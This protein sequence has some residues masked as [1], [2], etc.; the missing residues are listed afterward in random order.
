MR[1]NRNNLTNFNILT[2]KKKLIQILMLAFV[3]VSIGSFVSCKDTNEDLYNQ[4][5]SEL[6]AQT[7]QTLAAR[8][9][10][11]Q[12]DLQSHL[13]D[14]QTL[15]G[16]VNY[17]LT[18]CTNVNTTITNLQN[19][20]NALQAALGGDL[21][22]LVDPVTG[23]PTS[24]LNYLNYLT[25]QLNTLTQNYN[26]LAS[27]PADL[28]ALQDALNAAVADLQNQ[29][30]NINTSGCSCGDLV[31]RVTALEQKMATA[32][33]NI[34]AALGRLDN[35]EGAVNAATQ[36]AQQAADA[37][38]AAAQVA[39]QADA[40]ADEAL[41][42]AL[43]AINTA[44]ALQTLVET[45]TNN[46]TILQ[47]A[48]Q[49]IQNTLNQYGEQIGANTAAIQQNAQDIATNV[50]NIQKNADDIAELKNK[51]NE[52][53]TKLTL[54]ST[55][56]QEAFDKAT[57]ALA[58]AEV[59]EAAISTLNGQVAEHETAIQDL[60]TAVSTL[61]EQVNTNTS[62]I[63]T[64]KD[65]VNTLNTTVSEL[66]TKV[67]D[68]SDKL[69]NLENELNQ[70]KADCAT[71]LEA[72]KA[73]TDEQIAALKIDELAQQ[74]SDNTDAI[75]AINEALE[76]IKSCECDP[77][78]I[79]DILTRLA[80]AEGNIEDIQ[81]EIADVINKNIEE[82]AKQLN[83]LSADHD[84]LK[85]YVQN[86]NY[87]TPE[88]VEELVKALADNINDVTDDLADDLADALADIID[89][90]SR[91]ELLENTTVKIDDYVADKQDILDKIDANEV[92]I[93]DLEDRADALENQVATL[94]EDL[95]TLTGRV[96]AAE[97][98]LD[99]VEAEVKGLKEDVAALQDYLAKMV[100]G[101]TLQGTIN[102]WFGAISTPFDVQ[103]NILITFY[104]R[105]KSEIEFP[106]NKTGNYV[107]ADEALTDEDMEMIEGVE[108]FEN[109]ANVP[110]IYENGYA[111]KIYMTIN[112]NTADVT[113]L[114]PLIVNSKD[115]V[116][117]FT[118][119]PI[120]PCTEGALQFGWTS[121]TRAQ[122]SNG[123]YMAKVGIKKAD[124]PRISEPSFQTSKMIDALKNA[125]QA[126][127]TLAETHSTSGTASNL[128]KI[129][130]DILS[131]VK[132]LSFDRSGLKVSYT[133]TDA[134]GAET[135]HSVYSEYNLAATGFQPLGL[136]TL[137]D[138]DV[139]TIPGYKRA[140]NLLDRLAAKL[141]SEISVYFNDFSG[142][143]LVTK[144]AS[145]KIN[146]IDLDHNMDP[147]NFI[148]TIDEDVTID[149][150]VFKLVE[151]LN[152][153]K[154]CI[155][156]RIPA[157]LSGVSTNI[158]TIFVDVNGIDTTVL[159][160]PV[161]DTAG[162]VVGFATIDLNDIVADTANGIVASL[163]NTTI[164]L[165]EG[166]YDIPMGT[167]SR[168]IYFGDPVLDPVTGLPVFV[169]GQ[170]QYSSNKKFHLHVPID[171][172]DYAQYVLD[173]AEDNILTKLDEAQDL[174]DEVNRLIAKINNYED[175]IDG[176]I[177][178]Y[179]DRLQGYLDKINS[180][181]TRVLNTTNNR[182]QPFMVA[183]DSKGLKRLS[184][185]KNYPTWLQKNGT[186]LYP[187]SQT[188]ELFVPLARKHVAVT[189]VFTADL[190]KSAQG[191]DADCK[192]R[193][194]AANA[195]KMN[196]VLDGTVRE[197]KLT[198]MKYGYVYEIAYS[199]LDFH[200]KIATRKYYVTVY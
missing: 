185:A 142:S 159:V 90:T 56:A 126:I 57:D 72:A 128:T 182:F 31:N 60:K 158:P 164:P 133:T 130:S 197:L 161:A 111:G 81:K 59:N 35:L 106:T 184:T 178:S 198:G 74:V 93:S 135:V 23:E 9:N 187:T 58:K 174:V 148:L 166:T 85:L 132:G 63:Q 84:D 27:V 112:P 163:N 3:A 65:Q 193:L 98:R 116:S 162:N 62:D 19:Q 121:P 76:K 33:A 96:T 39:N 88:E 175:R 83:E 180:V 49:T 94:Q 97:Q 34:Q 95:N 28:A 168:T 89:L 189:N 18:C 42:N 179:V 160:I 52:M 11:L 91:V 117:P 170:P 138:L 21:S 145:F 55:Q 67:S 110:L 131:I 194:Q 80:T 195:E 51:I 108:I 5:R 155:I 44:T 147:N 103:S 129:A 124:L 119:E 140:S 139:K 172:R 24:I 4:L 73:Y 22:G 169:D 77:A 125:K 177:D 149:N 29:I 12:A 75:K 113:G 8:I 1:K 17:L 136:E 104:G 101:I 47:N 105:P 6:G 199:A 143:T 26:N 79:Q 186:Y 173:V 50:A 20:I 176:T 200:G 25:Q 114:Q 102:P 118:I 64:L 167:F 165:V 30:N 69:D 122:S 154:L 40:K 192:A 134:N 10:Q 156:N 107:R 191:D 36:L 43:N 16:N 37:A 41:Q 7:D 45:N 141:K 171:I 144:L 120:K 46:I 109:M 92:R 151:P 137:K 32:E 38:A 188:L 68:L 127:T 82:M 153:Y 14:Y 146:E 87:I 181:A 78:V 66:D 15:L 123:L 100:T 99:K 54:V 152:G 70:V 13:A 115:V 48:V 53:D 157:D 61:Q 190:S 71:N 2:M 86:L 196:T 150:C 183:S